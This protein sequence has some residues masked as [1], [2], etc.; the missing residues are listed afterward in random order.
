MARRT[1]VLCL[2]LAGLAPAAAF[3]PGPVLPRAACLAKAG[4][5]W[6]SCAV[7]P[8][9][10][11]KLLHAML[12]V[13]SVERAVAFWEARGARRL[14]EPG[15]GSCF[16]GYGEHRDATFFALELSPAAEPV[17]N[18][19]IAYIGLS[20][21]PP[22]ASLP[23]RTGEAEHGPLENETPADRFAAFMLDR[24]RRTPEGGSVDGI[25]VR[26]VASAPGDPLARFALSVPDP[27]ATAR[28]YCDI[29]GMR[30]VFR[31]EQEVCVRYVSDDSEGSKTAWGG[32]GG[33]NGGVPTTLVLTKET[34][35]GGAGVEA[36]DHLAVGCADV[37]AA[38]AAVWEGNS[39][40]VFLEPTPMFGTVVCGVKDPDGRKVYLV[41]EAGFRA[42]GSS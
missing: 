12:R 17:A 42:G 4:F 18:A 9:A 22:G 16:V 35:P 34:A 28:F 5:G 30:E 29:L 2:A 37:E 21:L 27:D 19:D 1:V 10:D 23:S 11:N 14:T 20:M 26:S 6:T 13:P 7:A 8:M 41:E 24:E 40:A 31:S 39:A 33:P 3:A 25:E 36:F 38:H 32:L 15:K